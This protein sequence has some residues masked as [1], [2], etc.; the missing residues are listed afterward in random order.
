MKSIHYYIVLIFMVILSS[1]GDEKMITPNPSFR[2][3]NQT[4]IANEY[5][6]FVSETFYV[7]RTGAGEFLTLYDGNKGKIWNDSAALG[8]QFQLN[9]SLPV[10]YSNAGSYNLTVVASSAG[11]F[12]N[13]YEQTT[14]TV[15]INVID[16]RA[17]FSSFSLLLDN[18]EYKGVI[19]GNKNIAISIPD[20]YSD[21]LSTAKPLFVTT[22]KDSKVYLNSV[23]QISGINVQNLT[24]TLTY[25]VTA[26]NGDFVEYKVKTLLYTSSSEKKIT[27]FALVND[28]TTGN[29][30]VG[31]IDENNKSININLNYAT[32]ASKVKVD[33][34]SSVSSTYLYNGSRAFGTFSNLSGS[35]TDPLKTIKVIAQNKTEQT[36]TVNATQEVPFKTFT[37]KGLT[38][39]PEGVI[40][41]T[42][43]TITIKVLKGTDITKLVAEW[44]GTI[45]KVRVGT[46]TI[47]QVNGTTVNDFST[48]KEYKL[49][50]G[51]STTVSD[52]YTITV[53]ILE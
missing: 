34:V 9:D 24:E 25:K 44:T 15:K 38:P 30:E 43:K 50:Q 35:G 14:K 47:N 46:G 45:G 1:C 48:K 21:L 42:A 2:L 28:K 22:S 52:T 17:A 5:T 36:Y 16:R 26:T 19:D 49:Y 32:F 41:N 6:C 20:I 23:E 10:V 37:F 33:I 31:I 11:K 12:G 51:T 7:V 40:D 8:V 18:T 53:V 4:Q 13:K 3:S 29:G 27:Q 39:T